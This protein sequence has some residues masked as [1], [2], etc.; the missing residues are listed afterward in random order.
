[1]SDSK[2]ILEDINSYLENEIYMEYLDIFE[3]NLIYFKNE[4]INLTINGYVDYH[5][6]FW[7]SVMELIPKIVKLYSLLFK[8]ININFHCKIFS[9][10]RYFVYLKI[11]CHNYYLSSQYAVKNEIT[12]V[13]LIPLKGILTEKQKDLLYFLNFDYDDLYD[14]E[15]KSRESLIDTSLMTNYEIIPFRSYF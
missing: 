1:M 7:L 14:E 6:L 12:F 5:S 2:F 15:I 3:D 10:M 11:Y 8:D 9:K 4:I 13:K